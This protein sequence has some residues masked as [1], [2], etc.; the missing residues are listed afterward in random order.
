MSDE[1]IFN[2]MSIYLIMSRLKIIMRKVIFYSMVEFQL[3]DFVGLV[4]ICKKQATTNMLGS[5]KHGRGHKPSLI[6]LFKM[7]NNLDF[8]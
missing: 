6:F 3:I 7:G 8:M 2:F 1:E 5:L 4:L